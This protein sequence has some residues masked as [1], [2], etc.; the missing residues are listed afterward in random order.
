MTVVATSRGELDAPSGQRAAEEILATQPRGSIIATATQDPVA[1]VRAA[2]EIGSALHS[3]LGVVHARKGFGECGSGERA[4]FRVVGRDN[5]VGTGMCGTDGHHRDTC[6]MRTSARRFQ[7]LG[8]HRL[9][10]DEI[11]AGRNEV[12]DLLRLPVFVL[13]GATPPADHHSARSPPREEP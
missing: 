5:R 10:Q 8:H 13:R 3:G 2:I 12:S 4:G 1:L 7:P 6:R 11:D 9:D